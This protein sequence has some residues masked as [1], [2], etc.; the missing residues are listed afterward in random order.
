MKIQMKTEVGPFE[1]TPTAAQLASAL[2][3]LP[4]EAFVRLDSWDSQRDG[5]GWRLHAHWAEDRR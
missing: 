3:L 4:G 2:A 5:A 1:G